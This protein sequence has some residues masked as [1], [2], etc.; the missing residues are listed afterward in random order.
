MEII[1][2][3]CDILTTNYNISFCEIIFYR[4]R[5]RSG[6]Q[7]KTQGNLFLEKVREHFVELSSFHIFSLRKGRNLRDKKVKC[8][9]VFH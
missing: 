1:R 2:G 4:V 8:F 6:K 9:N 5:I 3:N 7:G